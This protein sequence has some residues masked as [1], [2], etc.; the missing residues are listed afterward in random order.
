MHHTITEAATIKGA[1]TSGRM[2]VR[3]IDAGQGSSGFYPAETLKAAAEAG[4][5]HRGL[6]LY[7]DHPSETERID[8]P[9]RSIRDIAGVLTEDARYDEETE[10]LVAEAKTF[11]AWGP[12]LTEMHDAIGLSIR[13]AAEVS[14]GEHDGQATVIVD[15]IVAA[16]S[17]DFVTRAGRGGKVLSLLES[18][19]PVREAMSSDV[20][21]ALELLFI[22]DGNSWVVDH[23]PD[24]KFVIYRRDRR[25]WRTA[26]SYDPAT[27]T[28]TL[29]PAP[30]EVSKVVTYV[31]TQPTQN[32]P[33]PAGQTIT[34][35]ESREDTMPQIEEA[36]LRQLEEDAGRAPQL[37]EAVTQLTAERDAARAAAN[38]AL[39]A[40]LT[41]QATALVAESG[42]PFTSLERRGLIVDVPVTESG[43]LDAEKL[44]TRIEEAAAELEERARAAAGRG[45]GSVASDTGDLAAFD[46]IFG[47]VK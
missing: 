20:E 23:D 41:A 21:H 19:R 47:G 1:S 39:T 27:G 5:F 2:L 7:A 44:R 15:R 13:A 30:V 36:R 12:I 6:H 37:E 3:L 24:A 8:R 38:A 26:Y 25:T 11:A 22:N 18:A 32:V 34:T 33:A 29:D 43:E 35:Q 46:E 45:F 31:P 4:V 40:A 9:E 14:E 28:A 17:V 10:S 42:H 16:E